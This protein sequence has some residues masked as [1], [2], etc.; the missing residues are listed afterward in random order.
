MKLR[1]ALFVACILV[2]CDDDE[3]TIAVGADSGID[4]AID[5]SASDAALCGFDQTYVVDWTGSLQPPPTFVTFKAPREYGLDMRMLDGGAGKS[6]SITLPCGGPGV[7]AQDI[8]QRLSDPDFV[9]LFTDDNTI[10]GRAQFNAFAWAPRT[11][12]REDGKKIRIGGCQLEGCAD[13]PRPLRELIALFP[14]LQAQHTASW[15]SCDAWP[16]R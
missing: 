3:Q 7:D 2:A 4:A 8:A 9:A 14:E 5:A 13:F 1:N 6:C 10:L 12:Q 15:E 16:A 11:I